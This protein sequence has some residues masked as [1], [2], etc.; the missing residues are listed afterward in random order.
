MLQANRSKP[1]DYLLGVD[2]GGT[3][4]DLVLIRLSDGQIFLHKTPSTPA[5]PSLA[6]ERGISEILVKASASP[7]E[8]EYF[9]HGTTVATNA[10]IEGKMAVTALI[11]TA[12]FRDILEIRR[13]RQPHNY[14][15]RIPKPAPIVP[16]HLRREVP[17]RIFMS[18]GQDVSPCRADLDPHIADFKATKVAAIAVVFLHSYQDPSH[19]RQ[20]VE[21]LREALPD[22]FICASHEILAEFREYERTST[23]VTNAGLGPIMSSYLDKLERRVASLGLGVQPNIQQSN[24]GFASPHEAGH[25]PI[26]V[27]VSG[28]AAGVTGSVEVTKQAGFADVIT[29][30]VGG[31]STDV[32]VI[33]NSTPLIAREREVA[34]Y[35]VR[36]PMIDV[37]SVG[38]GGG[39]IAWIDSGGFLQVGPKSAGADP[40][41]A[42][43]DRG[44]TQPTVTDANVVLGRLN[45][46]ALLNGRMPIHSDLARTAIAQNIAK[47]LGVSIEDAAESILTI[48]N[49]TMVRAIR[50]M[51]VEQGID[52]RRFA[53]LAFGGAGP[54]LATSLARE[55]DIQTTIV[56]PGPGLLCALGLLMAD[57][58]RDFSKTS[59]FP[60]RMDHAQALDATARVLQAQADEWFASE[61]QLGTSRLLEWAADVRYLG[62][63][64]DLTVPLPLGPFDKNVFT[65]LIEAFAREHNR[66]YGYAPEAGVE[67]VTLRATARAMITRPKV[68]YRS[69][70]K[71]T[72][73]VER[74][75][76]VH[77]PRHGFVDCTIYDRDALAAGQRLSGPAIVEQ[78]D[79]TTVI[80]PDQQLEC[81]GSGNM[82]V[83]FV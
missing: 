27:L 71:S 37:H 20:V 41:P 72:T 45:P 79:T 36:F 49:E 69:G 63:S 52:P 54:L 47:P 78:M 33:Q 25:R 61:G 3:F 9:G 29:F 60:L 48:L 81:D 12:G 74:S 56:P 43:Y 15:I 59:I 80:F 42:C 21:W 35:P 57:A 10:V 2:V 8:I 50:V 14:N 62:Q 4:T 65:D 68:N 83:K 53:L 30:D 31:T 40:G 39:S 1:Q 6:M 23:T 26:S 51:T 55:L 19:E 67:M 73:G 22:V 16:R 82:I 13:Q 44:G 34:G 17:E 7:D 77:F 18:G 58:R 24:G 5:D 32:C 46:I 75:R 38:A 66:F 11:T 70:Q 76:P 28:P 64:H